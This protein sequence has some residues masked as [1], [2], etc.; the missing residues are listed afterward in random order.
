MK[1]QQQHDLNDCGPACLVMVA[2]QYK[3]YTTIGDMRSLCKTDAIGTNFAG[4]VNAAN[5]IGFKTVPLRGEVNNKTLNSKLVFPCIAHVKAIVADHKYDHYVVI[6]KITKES[7]F[8]Y[9]PDFQKGKYKLSRKEF[10]NI[11]TGYLLL[12]IPDMH[13]I[14]KKGDENILLKF[15]PLLA[16]YKEILATKSK[17]CYLC[18]SFLPAQKSVSHLFLLSLFL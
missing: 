18:V 6:K 8:I 14:P 13:F 1:Y 10:L 4:L 17:C 2:S 16:H 11:W 15:V 9:D 12:V 7:V 5:K 3:Y